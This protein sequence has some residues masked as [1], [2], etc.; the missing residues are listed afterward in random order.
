LGSLPGGRIFAL[1]LEEG[2]VAE[3]RK[4]K[5]WEEYEES[6]AWL[7]AKQRKEIVKE[8]KKKEELLNKTEKERQ[9]REDRAQKEWKK[10][11]AR[12]G[13]LQARIRFHGGVD[14]SRTADYTISPTGNDG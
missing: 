1:Q 7:S 14:N 9:K 8:E 2:T 5:A 4:S 10:N 12:A 11:K 13:G 3:I 6:N